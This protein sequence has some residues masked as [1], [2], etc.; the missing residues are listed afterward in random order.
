M[1]YVL[2]IDAG[3]TKTTAWLAM[4][5]ESRDF[6]VVGRG[7]AGGANL[8]VTSESH[9]WEQI[10]AAIAH[11]FADADLEPQTVQAAC[12]AVAGAGRPGTRVR[13][14]RWADEAR[15]ANQVKVVHDG[16]PVLF[17]AFPDGVGVALIAGTGSLAFGRDSSGRDVRSGG[18]GYLLGDEGSGYSIALAGLR[19]AV[20]SADGRSDRT[21]L[22]TG[23]LN[24]LD[25]TAVSELIDAIYDT[26][27]TRE[28]IASL[29]R[30]VFREAAAGDM[31][32]ARILDESAT[33]LARMCVNVAQQLGWQPS[34]YKLALT[35]GIAVHYPEFRTRIE[36]V[37]HQLQLPPCD[38]VVVEEPVAGA[39]TLATRH[40]NHVG[41]R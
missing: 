35:G 5:S 37:L 27:V 33:E 14:L 11:A 26:D 13:V 1:I 18:W 21:R 15:L 9:A 36:Q 22:L 4:L 17:A 32:A 10:S 38:I 19:A 8:Q 7:T 20:R 28:T 16:E 12:L 24:T 40:L 6:E 39:V 23:F 41:P 29:S 31:V 34:T 3:G 30:V 25:C 2:G